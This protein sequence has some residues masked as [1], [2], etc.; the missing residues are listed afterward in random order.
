MQFDLSHDYDLASIIQL[1]TKYYNFELFCTPRFSSQYFSQTYEK[2]TAILIRQMAKGVS[3]FIDVGAHY[4]FYDVLV[5]KSNPQ[6]E[7]FSYEPVEENVEVIQENLNF[8]GISAHIFQK[9]VSSTNGI[10]Q[11]EVSEAC[12]SSGFVAD[13]DF[14][15][16]KII[17]VETVNIDSLINQIGKDSLLIK[18]DV[19]GSE[20]SVLEGMKNTI[21]EIDDIRL[22][23]RCNTSC[24]RS[25]G[26]NP[27]KLFS[28]LDDLGFQIHIIDENNKRFFKANDKTDWEGFLEENNEC[29]LFCKKKEK[30]LNLCFFS[31]SSQL[32]GAERKLINL[33]NDLISEYGAL[34]TVI[35]PNTGPLKEKLSRIGCATFELPYFWWCLENENKLHLLPTRLNTSY[36]SIKNSAIINKLQPDLIITNTLVIPW[37]AVFAYEN[38]IPHLWMVNEFGEADHGI[39]FYFGLDQTTQ[40]IESY[41][42]KI[43]TCSKA[44]KNRLFQSSAQVEVIY[45]SFNKLR[46]KIE[47]INIADDIFSKDAAFHLLLPGT[48]SKGKGQLDAVKAAIELIN[49]REKNIELVL[50]GYS[51]INY[52]TKI[53]TL[54]KSENVEDRIRILPFIDG[55]YPIMKSAD[56]IIISSRNEAFGRVVVE[57]MLL[58]KPVIG[59]NAGGILELIQNGKTGLFYSPGDYLQLA[60]QIQLL[61][62]NPE[63]R[64]LMV[65][66]GRK[67]AV[68]KFSKQEFSGKFFSEFINLKQSE[69]VHSPVKKLTMNR[70]YQTLIAGSLLENTN[71]EQEVNIFSKEL[72]NK[73]LV[74]F[75]LKTQIDEYK[76][77]LLSYQL[78][79]SWRITRPLRK[80]MKI[81]KMKDP[82]DT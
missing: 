49:N 1:K 44:V 33:T 66:N 64:D 65:K 36:L 30:A 76:Q 72:K 11:F 38:R 43:I 39:F 67:F 59:T 56:A 28:K 52:L 42:D 34:C 73:N 69:K 63:Y 15:I 5:G 3:T 47:S 22:F 23:I 31:H 54:I 13:P 37:G 7:I 12:D 58:N 71:I 24:L 82:S 29:H 75:D 4:G 55:I 35:L 17:D 16:L 78:S 41:S 77:E 74:I 79:K 60:D 2:M 80:L 40:F 50:V 14:D 61:M 48:I 27:S 26:S 9:A 32:A 8:H 57:G 18:I 68:N 51:N 21:E 25:N 19:G 46:N 10:E 6:C 81:L 45:D 62:E 70:F 53:E 20:I